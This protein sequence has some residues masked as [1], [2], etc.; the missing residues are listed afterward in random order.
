MIGI[1]KED[2]YVVRSYQVNYGVLYPF[3][4]PVK[5]GD[6]QLGEAAESKARCYE[7]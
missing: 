6:N 4:S 7:E 5:I 1:K 2:G 3:L